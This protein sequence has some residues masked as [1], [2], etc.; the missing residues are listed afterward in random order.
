[1]FIL[2]QTNLLYI[3]MAHMCIRNIGVHGDVFPDQCHLQFY[4][5]HCYATVSDTATL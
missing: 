5:H 2:F 4:S 3:Y 1:M